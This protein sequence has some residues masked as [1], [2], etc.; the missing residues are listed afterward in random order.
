MNANLSERVSLRF[1]RNVVATPPGR[2][3]I[4][5]QVADAEGSD[6]G[7]IFDHLLAKVDDAELRR[8]VKR[9][10]DDEVRH[11]AMFRARVDA[12]GVTAPRVPEELKILPRIAKRLDGVLSNEI[13]SR[14]D[15]MNAYIL[16]QVIE[17]RAVTRFPL[18]EEAF[19]AVDP[20]TADVFVA[21]AK[22]EERHLKYCH[23]IA[24]R[25]AP[26][27]ETHAATLTRFR[28]AEAAVFAETSA[29]NME[30]LLEE[31]IVVLSRRQRVLWRG[32]GL[33]ARTL[34]AQARTRFWKEGPAKAGDVAG[35]VAA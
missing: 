26:D 4:L 19:R 12:Q 11:A 17:E 18:F 31:G 5:S 22:D 1:L 34:G 9:H 14:R 28:R 3:Y 24:R 27:A 16:L 33:V 10:A 20:E 30:H 35:L 6:E 23:A 15:I 25:Y 8:L 32:F 29:L 13:K 21:V 2:A 7:A